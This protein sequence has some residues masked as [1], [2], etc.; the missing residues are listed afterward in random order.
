MIAVDIYPWGD[1]TIRQVRADFTQYIT[2][3]ATG[4]IILAEDYKCG[5]SLHKLGASIV[6]WQNW[7]KFPSFAQVK[8]IAWSVKI[9]RQCYRN[10]DGENMISGWLSGTTGWLLMRCFS[11]A[12]YHLIWGRWTLPAGMFAHLIVW[13]QIQEVDTELVVT[14][15]KTHGG[16]VRMLC[17]PLK[18]LMAPAMTTAQDFCCFGKVACLDYNSQNP[19]ASLWLT[20]GFQSVFPET[21]SLRTQLCES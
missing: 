2:S 1:R 17:S 15:Q 20:R 21:L 18:W 6:L 11:Q 3:W 7:W 4:I 14:D 5:A 8:R 19:K 9:L 10:A 12:L 16:F 13:K